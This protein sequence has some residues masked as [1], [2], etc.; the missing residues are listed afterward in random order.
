MP[1][2][3]LRAKLRQSQ[4]W[5]KCTEAAQNFYVRLLML[6][7]D[8]GR[9]EANP[10]LLAN[11]AYPYGDPETNPILPPAITE[12]LGVL[13]EHDLLLLYEVEGKPYL[14]F[15]RWH[16]RPRAANSFYPGPETTNAK[17]LPVVCT[18]S[19]K[20][21]RPLS[22]SL[23]LSLSLSP[24]AGAS[25]MT[26][27]CTASDQ[28]VAGLVQTVVERTKINNDRAVLDEL[29]R[30]LSIAYGRPSEQPWTYGDESMLAEIARRPKALEELG[31]LMTARYRMPAADRKY[32]PRSIA[33][34]IQK[35]DE[36]LDAV[37]ALKPP[38]L[39]PT[40]PFT[41]P[42]GAKK[43][44]P[45]PELAAKLRSQLET[46]LHQNEKGNA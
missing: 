27:R 31:I 5:N 1:N 16:D 3:I 37:R 23:S 12:R 44:E 9:Y 42:K 35:W 43:F 22:P 11:E 46:Q 17:Q 20:R 2:R 32:F 40:R 29:K 14:Q 13:A 25:Q 24:S 36:K 21:L 18:S 38:P 7:D 19:A 26:S 41:P 8:Y 33:S 34:L 15:T 6:V 30:Q 10:V 4:R 39:K 45:S 28:S